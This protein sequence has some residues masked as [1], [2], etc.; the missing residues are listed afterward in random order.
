MWRGWPGRRSGAHYLGGATTRGA[1]LALL[2]HLGSNFL[3]SPVARFT[4]VSLGVSQCPGDPAIAARLVQLLRHDAGLLRA[5]WW[6]SHYCATPVAAT[7]RINGDNPVSVEAESV[8]ESS[9]DAIRIPMHP[10]KHLQFHRAAVD[11]MLETLS[12][13][14]RHRTPPDNVHETKSIFAISVSCPSQSWLNHSPLSDPELR[15]LIR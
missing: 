9:T 10:E 5:G 4:E 1:V 13:A 11:M 3:T 6:L 2:R 12:D 7:L 8:P 15:W 14:L